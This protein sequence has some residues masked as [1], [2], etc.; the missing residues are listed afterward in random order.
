MPLAP[1]II[2]NDGI[3]MPSLGFG[4]WPLNDSEAADA[5]TLA[6]ASG[7]RMIDTASIYGNETG[8]GE[9][10]RRAGLPRDELFVT[11]KVRGADQGYDAT[12][13]ALE[14]S[15]QRLGLDHVDLYLIHWPLPAKDLYVD[16]WRAL[17]TLR[18]AGKTRSIGVSNFTPAYIDR[19]LAETGATPSV[20]QIEMH[21]EFAQAEQRRYNQRHGIATQSWSPLG[22]GSDVLTHP[23]LQQL[24]A[25]HDKSPAQI[26]LR[27]HV[28]SGAVPI[29]K[30]QHAQRMKANLDVFDFVLDAS[31][32]A[33][34]AQ[35]DAGARLGGDPDTHVEN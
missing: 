24:A 33:A 3:A 19:L 28:Q 31:D 23:V 32:M 22:R 13:R 2:L 17:E 30:S 15:L 29:P 26:A 16:T 10:L 1:N 7:Y 27:W 14:Q 25:K 35:L 20:N 18:A 9:G 8:V 12:L 11:T 5:V 34:L 4:T 21:L 6:I